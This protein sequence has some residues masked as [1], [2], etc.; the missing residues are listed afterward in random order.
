[1]PVPASALARFDDGGG[2]S[3]SS[4][5]LPAR[6]RD[7][8]SIRSGASG[9]VDEHATIVIVISANDPKRSRPITTEKIARAGAL[10][11]GLPNDYSYLHGSPMILDHPICASG[12]V[13]TL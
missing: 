12:V 9:G 6:G 1:M 4:F 5:V 10:R 7:G 11:S 2:S 13:A 8:D 3:E